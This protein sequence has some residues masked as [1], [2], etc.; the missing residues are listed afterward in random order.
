MRGDPPRHEDH[1]VRDKLLISVPEAAARLS[2]GRP[3][4]YDLIRTNRLRTVKIGRRRL[5]SPAALLDAIA[6]LEQE[7]CA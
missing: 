6:H 1:T 4:L 5:V 2:I 7:T 3:A